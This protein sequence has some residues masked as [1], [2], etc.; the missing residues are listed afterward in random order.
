VLLEL[1][2]G[3]DLV[4]TNGSVARTKIFLR[5][6]QGGFHRIQRYRSG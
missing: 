2:L 4:P 3:S 6:C 1:N 5:E